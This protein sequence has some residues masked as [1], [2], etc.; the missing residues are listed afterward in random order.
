M[1]ASLASGANF[2]NGGELYGTPER[3]SLHVLREYFSKYPEDAKK[4]V[5]SIKGG[6]V[7]GKAEMD[8][9]P[10]NVRRSVDECL[11]ILDGK[12]TLDIFECAR[13]DPKV[14]IEETIGALV[15]LVKEEKIKGIGL[16]EVR[17]E[18]IRRA[19]KVHPIAA[20]EVEL[21]LWA[22]DILHNGVA[23]TC[24]E[25]GIPIAAYSP[26]MRGA[27]TGQIKSK[28]DIPEGDPRKHMP[29]FQDDVMA[30]NMKVT[31]EVEKLAQKKGVTNAQ[32]AIGWVRSLSGRNGMP[33]I[34]PIPGASTEQ[35][36]LEN[37]KE[38]D[39]TE[40]EMLEIE[41]ILKENKVIGARNGGPAAALS[42]Y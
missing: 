42:E 10:E 3:N 13:V 11:R 9:R 20:V 8:C 22:T 25:L 4:V 12:K 23:T 33:I 26:L 36:V 39:L 32:I 15:E 35:R 40:E 14:A 17:A 28:A 21:S 16:S 27:L 7:P 6:L 34:I 24:A 37:S 1:R 19:H 38:V 18:T 30:G 31:H 5:L 29:K 2:W 41:S